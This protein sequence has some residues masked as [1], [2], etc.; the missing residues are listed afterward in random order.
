LQEGDDGSPKIAGES[1]KNIL[2]WKGT[3]DLF[4]LLAEQYA[5]ASGI[6]GVQPKVVVSTRRDSGDT[7]EKTSIKDRGLIIKSSGDDFPELAVNEYIC[8]SIAKAAG[9]EVPNFWLSDDK[10]L[11][12]VER[13]DIGEHGYIG[14]EDMTSLMNR[15][16]EEKYIGSY[17]QV[18]KAVALFASENFKKSSLNALFSS[19]ALSTM[20]RNGDA[21]LKNFGLLYTHPRSDDCRLS[22]LFDVVNTSAYIP[23]DVL[24]LKLNGT[25]AWPLKAEL[26]DFGKKHCWVD[27]PEEVLERIAT[28]AMAYRPDEDSEIWRKMKPEI[29]MGCHSLVGA[30]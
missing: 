22:P 8:M 3:E 1:L 14:F 10:K 16:N 2:T 4:E 23:K 19:V 9:L 25:K 30:A 27:R 24:A 11:F 29:N 6:S 28:A 26:I 17:E 12:V 21:H 13:F 15:Q 5:L 20:L 18:A 7:I